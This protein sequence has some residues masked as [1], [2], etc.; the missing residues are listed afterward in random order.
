[1]DS[2]LHFDRHLENVARKASHK[3]F[4]LRHLNHLLT[5]DGLLTLY[6]A[7]VRPLTW[8]SSARYHLNLLDQVQRRAEQLIR[9]ANMPGH[10]QPWQQHQHQRQRQQQQQR[11]I[12]PAAAAAEP[13]VR[14]SLGMKN[15]IEKS[16]RILRSLFNIKKLKSNTIFTFRCKSNRIEYIENFLIIHL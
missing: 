8:M 9:G 2:Q 1:M 16:I 11:H 5:R 7:Q 4:L 15:K 10:Q 6:K 12:N 13:A 3:V 14:D